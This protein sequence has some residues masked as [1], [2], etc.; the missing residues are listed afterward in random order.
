MALRSCPDASA[1][2]WLTSSELPWHQLVTFGPSG[3]NAYARLRFLPDPRQDGQPEIVLDESAPAEYDPLRATLEV[4]R[5]HTGAPGDVYFCVWDGWGP[6]GVPAAVLDSP[7]V[8]VPNRSYF[9][10]RGTLSDFANWDPAGVSSAHQRLEMADPAFIWPAD[11]AWCVAHDVDPHYAGIGSTADAIADLLA[12][13]GLDVVLS[14]P[15]LEQL[16]YG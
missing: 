9:L 2:A 6:R 12:H 13:S 16:H 4:L 10:L 3:F 11:H 8:N 1:A 7:R 14:D 5:Q 15:R